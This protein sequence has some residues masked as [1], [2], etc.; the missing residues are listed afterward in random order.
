MVLGPSPAWNVVLTTVSHRCLPC[1]QVRPR[2][3]AARGGLCFLASVADASGESHAAVLAQSGFARGRLTAVVLSLRARPGLPLR[4]GCL[5]RRRDRAFRAPASGV[6][7]S[8]VHRS[9]AQTRQSAFHKVSTISMSDVE[10]RKPPVPTAPP[11]LANDDRCHRGDGKMAAAAP[12]SR[13]LLAC[14]VAHRRVRSAARRTMAREDCGTVGGA[15]ALWGF[16][17]APDTPLV[18]HSGEDRCLGGGAYV[19]WRPLAPVVP[20][21]HDLCAV[22]SRC[23]RRMPGR[24]PSPRRRPSRSA[25][26]R[27]AASARRANPPTTRCLRATRGRNESP[28]SR[29]T[30]R[31]LSPMK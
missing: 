10:V 17:C 3:P 18:P 20:K 8:V 5:N 30:N 6:G 31:Q 1:A 11:S 7:G 4:A 12:R 14:L 24:S 16:T 27:S 28:L 25:A 22:L 15:C 9:G 29:P 21:S 23:A 19:A 2:S 13:A 26:S